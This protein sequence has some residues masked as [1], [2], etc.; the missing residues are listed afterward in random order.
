M[1]PCLVLLKQP[2]ENGTPSKL[3]MI[4]ELSIFLTC[5]PIFVIVWHY[6]HRKEIKS[7]HNKDGVHLFFVSLWVWLYV[8]SESN[9]IQIQ[10]W[11]FWSWNENLSN[12]QR[13]YSSSLLSNQQEIL[14]KVNPLIITKSQ[15]LFVQHE[16][17]RSVWCVTWCHVVMFVSI[18]NPWDS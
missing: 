6:I 5:S 15:L 2:T 12:P 3:F 11:H 14:S 13:L 1:I 4:N 16:N 10:G 18:N 8:C 9:P 7:F 17:N